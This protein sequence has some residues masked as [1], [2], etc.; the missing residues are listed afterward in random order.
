MLGTTCMLDTH[1]Q[2]RPGTL[3][4]LDSQ[5]WDMGRECDVSCPWPV[6]ALGKRIERERGRRRYRERGKEE[7]KRENR[8]RK[9]AKR[10]KEKSQKERENRRERE[11]EKERHARERERE[12]GEGAA[13]TKGRL[14]QAPYPLD[15]E[16]LGEVV[17]ACAGGPG[18]RHPGKALGGMRWKRTPKFRS[19]KVGP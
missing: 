19:F 10:R 17:D 16:G 13:C 9:R 7:K 6:L 11:R 5:W 15:R 8:G 12:R 18:V 1:M 14:A 3:R 4:L 2:T